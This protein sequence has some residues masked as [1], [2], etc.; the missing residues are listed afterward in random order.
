VGV[1]FVV[2]RPN[3]RFEIRESV[4]TPDGPRARSLAGFRVLTDEILAKAAERAQRPFD[5]E[6][7]LASGRRAGA[8]TMLGAWRKTGEPSKAGDA[9]RRFVDASRRMARALQRP[10]AATRADPGTTLIELLGFA[11]AVAC[12]QPARPFAPLEFPVMS[13]LRRDSAPPR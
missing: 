12:S 5:A 1:A 13:R 6:T 10:P 2:T 3:G 4:H 7:V 11:D 9:P 8:T